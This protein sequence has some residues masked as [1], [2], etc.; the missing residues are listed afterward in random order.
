[1]IDVRITFRKTH[2]RGYGV[3]I[4]RDLG[5]DLTMNPAPG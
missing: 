1:V 2:R 3:D 4:A 5:E